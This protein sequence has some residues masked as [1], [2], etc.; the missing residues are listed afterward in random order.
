MELSIDESDGRLA[1]L[2]WSEEEIR[3]IQSKLL[4]SGIWL[5][6]LCLSAH[7]R[8]PFGS[9]DEKKNGIKLKASC[10]RRFN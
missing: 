2:D 6:S 5:H 3:M 10:T 8:F 9:A 4:A 7:R 1:R